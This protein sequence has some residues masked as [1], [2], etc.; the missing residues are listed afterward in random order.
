MCR[1]LADCR[2]LL[3]GMLG[4][5]DPAP[6]DPRALRGARIA[7][8]PRTEHFD[9]EAEC[10]AGLDAALAALRKA[11]AEIV[12]VGPPPTA[13]EVPGVFFEVLG[14]EMLAYHRRFDDRRDGYRGSTRELLEMA[15][16]RATTAEQLDEAFAHRAATTDAWM[17][18]LGEHR[19]DAIVEPTEPFVAPVRGS[20]YDAWPEPMTAADGVVIPDPFVALTYLWDWTGF[21]V[22][23]LPAGLG[24]TSGLPVGVSLIGPTATD[25]RV[26]ALGVALQAELG[27]PVAPR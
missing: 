2:V 5:D 3:A 22:A 26:A 13:L 23:A 16:K 20:G 19:L 14:A 27:V 4:E 11:G 7:V 24:A 1:T 6:A 15:E 17:R 9:I 18:W 25:D 10:S 8:S 21:P 12:A